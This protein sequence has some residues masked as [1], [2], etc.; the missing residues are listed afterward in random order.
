MRERR[1]ELE[2]SQP[3][4]AGRIGIT[5]VTKDYVSRWELG[6]VDASLGPYLA[7]IATAL[8]TTEAD[9]MAG[10]TTERPEK[11]QTPDHPLTPPSEAREA[12]LNRIEADLHRIVSAL[13]ARGVLEA[14][15]AADRDPERSSG[16][17]DG[18]PHAK[19]TP[20]EADQGPT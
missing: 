16:T 18:Q 11:G 4:V 10:P 1:A 19:E 8:E 17:A 14:V 12:Q 3:E 20:P 13:E 9:L 2:L 5:S 6:K 15:D 7:K